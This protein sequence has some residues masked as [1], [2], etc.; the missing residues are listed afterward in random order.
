[1]QR[2]TKT[3]TTPGGKEFEINAY[4][5]GRESLEIRAVLT[6][7]IKVSIDDISTGKQSMEEMPASLVTD[8]KMK[9]LSLILVSLEGNKENVLD[10][11]LDLSESEYEFIAEKA[12]EVRVPLVVKK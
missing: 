2:E 3:F 11:V 9:A 12:E 1:M 7:G 10:R 8:Q 4:L 5:T 6:S